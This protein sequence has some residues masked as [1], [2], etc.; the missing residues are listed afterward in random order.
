[1]SHSTATS[2]AKPP[3]ALSPFAHGAFAMLWTATTL[4]HLGTWMHDVAA[5]WLMAEMTEEPFMVSLVRTAMAI[6]TFMFILLAGALADSVNKR[7]YLIITTLFLALV[8]A[9]MAGVAA[10]DRMTPEVLLGMTFLLGI[11]TA[12]LAP[13]MQSVVPHLVPRDKLAPTLALS[14]L[15]I[16][17]SRAVGPAIAG[18]LII[19]YGATAPFL[20]NAI[21][22]LILMITIIAWRADGLPQPAPREG[23]LMGS[24]AEGLRHARTNTGL[25]ATLVRSLFF[26]LTATAFW[27]LLP[28]IAKAVGGEGSVLLGT[29]VSMV[30]A[31]AVSGAVLLPTMRR[32]T[33][34]KRISEIGSIL[35]GLAMIALAHTSDQT[36]IIV[37]SA[38][39]GLGWIW[40]LTS[41]H[42]S[43]Q[44]SLPDWVRARGLSINLMMFFGG[45]ALGSALWGF[46]A[47][48]TDTP[49]A[50]QLAGGILILLQLPL[51][52]FP[53]GASVPDGENNKALQNP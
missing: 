2:L 3:S 42:L 28:V 45:Q 34:I 35:L 43:A 26:F 27:A 49:F 10:A 23:G 39:C 44:L 11:G 18:L 22:F 53:L 29:L 1:M 4:S 20:A 33:T 21:S 17:L 13:G 47:S 24:I 36:H 41:L 37:L 19:A 15:S 32:V 16:N 51:L 25:K 30:G 9:L 14:S 40:V 46:V 31:G 50:I 7:R 5:G 52:R 38:V 6:P 12:F 48:Q 8:A